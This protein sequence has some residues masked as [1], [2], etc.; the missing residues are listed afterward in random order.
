M[1]RGGYSIFFSGSSYGGFASSM[2]A[3]PPFAKNASLTTST[4]DPLTLE[5]GFPA[6]PSQTITNTYAIDK[7]YK[8]AYAQTWSFALQQ[9][10]YQNRY[11]PSGVVGLG[12]QLLY[13]S[14]SGEISNSLDTTDDKYYYNSA[15]GS[16]EL[17]EA[18]D[19]TFYIP[20]YKP[21]K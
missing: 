17:E 15:D 11:A 12:W 21:W 3:Q 8:L 19:G 10:F 2:A 16:F 13:G 7:N 1:I 4:A 18:L 14:I 6:E 9:T 5:N 20:E